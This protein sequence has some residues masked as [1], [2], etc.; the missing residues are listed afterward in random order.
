MFTFSHQSCK[1]INKT[2]V[3]VDN[4]KRLRECSCNSSS[5]KYIFLLAVR[6]YS[7]K[8]FI[9]IQDLSW[10]VSSYVFFLFWDC[11]N[12]IS[13]GLARIYKPVFVNEKK[14]YVPLLRQINFMLISIYHQNGFS[15][16]KNSNVFFLSRVKK[17]QTLECMYIINSTLEPSY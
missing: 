16:N 5:V 17:W 14:N 1:I 10:V 3:I 9:V 13:H 4:A 8:L 11:K 7:L 2:Y 6:E 12:F 15:L